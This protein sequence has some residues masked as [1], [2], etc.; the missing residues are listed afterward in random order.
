MART[1]V[2][3][4]E[5]RL[6]FPEDS[7]L[8]LRIMEASVFEQKGRN[9]NTWEKLN[10]KFEILGIIAIGGGGNV[11]DYQNWIGEPMY[12]S[13]RFFMSD[14]PDNQLRNWVEAILH[15]QLNGQGLPLGF[16]FDTNMIV[17]RNCKGVTS[18]YTTTRSVDPQTGLGYTRHQ[19]EH[20][21]PSA[22]GGMAVQSPYAQQQQP[23]QQQ[24]WAQPPA[25]AQQGWGQPPVQQ[26]A[27]Q[28]QQAAQQAPQQGA[29]QGWGAPGVVD[30]QQT[31]AQQQAAAYA[32][33][34]PA[35]QQVVPQQ[36]IQQPQPPAPS[37]D[38]WGGLGDPDEP[39]F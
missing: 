20:L 2:Q 33:Q 29:Q 39:G 36:Q 11:A 28:Y 31:F 27:P 34:Q 37:A 17:G 24:Q 16:E 32:P 8:E 21:L 23:V 9:D 30:G 13:C 35:Q 10:L 3:H 12:G 1:T 18:T 26:A 5:D 15:D 25:Q 6:T 38:P 22:G 4:Q 19:V 14:K 7:L